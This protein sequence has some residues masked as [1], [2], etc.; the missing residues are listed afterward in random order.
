MEINFKS[1]NHPEKHVKDKMGLLEKLGPTGFF[2]GDKDGKIIL[3]NE[4]E[5]MTY[6]FV[7]DNECAICDI[8][9]D[10]NEHGVNKCHF[11]YSSSD[12]EDN[13]LKK[14]CMIG[15]CMTCNDTYKDYHS[16]PYILTSAYR[17]KRSVKISEDH[18]VVVK[19]I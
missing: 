19:L 13:D 12:H 1:R 6:M 2:K 18:N 8:K 17:R 5:W 15:V 16:V 4:E 9:L 10:R 11:R 3:R 14:I 7:V